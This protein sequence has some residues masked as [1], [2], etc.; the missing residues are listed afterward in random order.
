MGHYLHFFPA[1]R[2]SGIFRRGKKR[3][4][5][6]CGF[7]PRCLPWAG[8]ET[9]KEMSGQLSAK[10]WP[11]GGAGRETR[12]VKKE[13]PAISRERAAIESIP[14]GTGGTRALSGPSNF[15]PLR[16]FQFFRGQRA[17]INLPV[18]TGALKRQR[19]CDSESICH[20]CPLPWRF[21]RRPITRECATVANPFSSCMTLPFGS[22]V[23]FPR[24][25][26][27]FSRPRIRSL[28]ALLRPTGAIWRELRGSAFSFGKKCL[29]T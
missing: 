24:P 19:R 7:L 27:S 4:G 2:R 18:F 29:T 26:P 9:K 10:K 14:R 23:L 1:P 5:D 3:R 13:W 12:L 20:C 22:R 8:R 28:R 21:L 11:R 6:F 25:L 16:D 15:S 17:G